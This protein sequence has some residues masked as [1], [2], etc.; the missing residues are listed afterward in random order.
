[1]MTKKIIKTL[2]I[3]MCCIFSL[4]G[5]AGIQYRSIDLTS[6]EV[7]P[8]KTDGKQVIQRT[9]N[10]DI[11]AKKTLFLTSKNLVIKEIKY[12]FN[13]GD[14]NQEE[15]LKTEGIPMVFEM[16]NYGDV[17]SKVTKQKFEERFSNVVVSVREQP[18]DKF[19]IMIEPEISGLYP[20]TMTVTLKVRLASGESITEQGTVE[21]WNIPPANL[22][23]ILPLLIVT[24][25][26]GDLVF[27]FVEPSI[28]N[29]HFANDVVAAYSIAAEKLADKIAQRYAHSGDVS[30]KRSK[31]ISR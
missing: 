9:I 12:D 21:M 7:P 22:I 20:K 10:V 27:L 2:S 19:G 8:P 29:N 31:K 3:I 24:F 11:I 30:I 18:S 14:K 17:V 4:C 15:K 5:C 26:E 25:P 6:E 16:L 23:W 1:M 28:E 13:K